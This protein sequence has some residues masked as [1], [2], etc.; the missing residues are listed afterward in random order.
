MLGMVEFPDAWAG[1]LPFAIA[2]VGGRR[3]DVVLASSPP[4]SAALAGAA[5]A[6]LCHSTLVLD[7]RDP[8]VDVLTHIE[9]T[10]A[11]K[12]ML[13]AHRLAEGACLAGADAVLCATPSIQRMMIQRCEA[14]ALLL[15]NGLDRSPPPADDSR[16]DLVYAGSLAYGRTLTPILLALASLPESSNTPGLRL[17]YAGPHS[18]MALQQA[19]AAGVPDRLVDH[20]LLSVADAHDLHAQARAAVAISAPGYEY[21]IPGKVFDVLGAGTP[22]LVLAR[23]DADVAAFTR[24]NGLGWAHD[25]DDVAG[26]AQTLSAIEAG[27]RPAMSG[28]ADLDAGRQMTWLDGVLRGLVQGR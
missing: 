20:G 13:L 16:T 5:L 11:Q 12:R 1:W 7:Y 14:P 25:H 3:F 15:T 6:S 24:D 8:W 4:Y 19:E 2:A 21:A 17:H 27:E 26:L 23:N 18:A 10:A 28:L 9:A 22:L